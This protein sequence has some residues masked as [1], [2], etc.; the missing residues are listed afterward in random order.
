MLIIHNVTVLPVVGPAMGEGAVAID[1]GRVLSV[2]RA[3][4][5]DF[6][7]LG[8]AV[9]EAVAAGAAE[10]FDGE[11]GVLTPGLIDAHT[12]LGVSEEA[13]GIEGADL[14]EATGP[15]TP[16]ARRR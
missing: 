16:A 12:H 13:V 15:N 3:R 2:G 11:G 7:S 14:N 9:T 1:A 6:A 10:L 5:G 8:G 4:G